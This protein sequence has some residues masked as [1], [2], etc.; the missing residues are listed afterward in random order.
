LYFPYISSF[1]GTEPDPV[2]QADIPAIYIGIIGYKGINVK[3]TGDR[4]QGLSLFTI[5][6]YPEKR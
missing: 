1:T 4:G 6:I 3:W 5:K 2:F